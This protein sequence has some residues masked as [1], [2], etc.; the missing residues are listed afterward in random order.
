MEVLHDGK[1][2][3]SLVIFKPPFS[4]T[5]LLLGGAYF[6]AEGF[7]TRPKFVPARKQWS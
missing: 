2:I 3:F 4:L 5:T 1:L 7:I 6:S